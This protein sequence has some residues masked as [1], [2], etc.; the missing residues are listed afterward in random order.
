MH[1]FYARDRFLSLI[2][3]LSSSL[4]RLA[5]LLFLLHFSF[6]AVC[7]TVAYLPTLKTIGG[8]AMEKGCQERGE[9][10]RQ[11]RVKTER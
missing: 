10:E 4:D 3:S 8:K 7:H 6:K 2:E 9:I 1:I 5:V 11:I